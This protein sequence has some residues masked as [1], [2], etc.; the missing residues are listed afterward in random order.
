[1]G[2]SETPRF[3]KRLDL[4]CFRGAQKRKTIRMGGGRDK[5]KKHDKKLGKVSQSKLSGMAK[6]ERKTELNLH[7]KKSRSGGKEED[8]ENDIERILR[9]LKLGDEEKRE[10]RVEENCGRPE[11]GRASCTL[12]TSVAKNA[13]YLFGGECTS[14]E[15]KSEKE[16]TTKTTT[17]N[18][19]V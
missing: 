9:E 7:K 13:A 12:T 8:E 14:E 11:P 5:R 15:K 2:C 18:A 17:K 16:G 10:V 4:I 3:I 19:R 1:M 6:T